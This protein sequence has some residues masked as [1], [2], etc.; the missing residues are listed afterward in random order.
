MASVSRRNI[1]DGRDQI[2]NFTE[3]QLEISLSNRWKSVCVGLR[4]VIFEVWYVLC[5]VS[6]VKFMLWSTE[7]RALVVESYC[8]SG[9]SF[10]T[11]QRE[12]RNHINIAPLV[13]FLIGNQFFFMGGHLKRNRWCTEKKPNGSR[14]IR[15]LEIIEESKFGISQSKTCDCSWDVW[16]F[17]KTTF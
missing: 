11:P 12:W 4:E 9:R 10:I 6:L 14:T 16:S 5:N 7:E 3:R 8:S 2:F 15:T 17:C 13:V 1:N